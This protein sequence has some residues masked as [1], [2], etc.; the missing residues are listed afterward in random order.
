MPVYELINPSDPYTF[1]AP[2]I[3]V[4][5]VVAAMLSTGFGAQRVGD[6]HLNESTPIMF[7]WDKWM[8]EHGIDDDWIELHRDEIADAFDS[9][10]IGKFEDR[11]DVLDMLA[12]LPEEKQ[13]AWRARRQ[14][15][16][17][18]SLNRIGEAAYEYA[19]RL[20]RARVTI[21]K[22]STLEA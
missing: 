21:G 17:R 22:E 4:A 7:G 6:E 11:Q 10:L 16:H 19:K 5:G 18:S 20:R 8:T 12:E 14:D 13:E 3:E 1:E 2:S 15:R 9:F